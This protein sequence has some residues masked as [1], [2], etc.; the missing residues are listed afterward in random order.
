MSVE[1][2]SRHGSDITSRSTI[3]IETFDVDIAHYGILAMCCAV[4]VAPRRCDA[5]CTRPTGSGTG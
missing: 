1:F 5:H 4:I 3:T 2:V